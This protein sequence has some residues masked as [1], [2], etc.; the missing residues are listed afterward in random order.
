ME[1]ELVYYSISQVNEYIKVLF[2]NTITLKNIYL[3]GEISNYKGRN[4]SGHIY[5]TLKDD[6][7]SINAVLFKYDTFSLDFEPK[8]GDEVLVL[9]S[10]SSY[11]PSGT[12]QII[13]KNVSLFGVGDSYL[14]KELLKKKLFQEGIFNIEHKKQI[15]SYPINIGIITGKNSAAALDFEFNLK[16]RFPLANV[17]IIPSLVQGENAAQDLIKNLTLADEKSYDL[18]I[19]GRGGGASEDLSAFDDEGLVRCIYNLKTPII[20]A[21]GHEINQTLCDLVADKYASTPTGAAEIAVPNIEDVLYDLSQ[22]KNYLESLINSKITNLENRILKIKNLK[23]FQ[24]I[25]GIY[26]TYSNKIS[27]LKDLLNLKISNYLDN[28][29]KKIDLEKR[30]LELLNPNNLLKKGYSI[31]TDKDGRVVSS[32]DNVNIDD[33][34]NIKI[35]DGKILTKVVSKEK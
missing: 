15:P 9:G 12:Y 35:S 23:Y 19:I 33:S 13:C 29:Q 3:K 14:K 5:F 17:T 8:N 7:C 18:L 16:R 22:T 31:V 21:V 2:D 4:K 25:E 30:S 26:E 1:K 20:S 32:L 6:K 10:I 27:S 11:P 24:N 28:F 34:L